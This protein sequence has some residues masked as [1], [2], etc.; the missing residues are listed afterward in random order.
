MP[1]DHADDAGS[2][3]LTPTLDDDRD[4]ADPGRRLLE[5]VGRG[6]VHDLRRLEG[7]L[8]LSAPLRTHPLPDDVAVE[9]RRRAARSCVRDGDERSV[10]RLD[11]QDDV[12]GGE[13]REELSVTG[14][15]V[16]PLHVVVGQKALGLG[17]ITEG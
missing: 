9:E 16:Q 7:A 6:G 8:H 5:P 4:G 1:G 3:I 13:V 14:E 10:V 11:P 17:E 12:G 2:L 15:P